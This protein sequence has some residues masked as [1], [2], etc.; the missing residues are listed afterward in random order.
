MRPITCCLTLSLML[1][2]FDVGSQSVTNPPAAGDDGWSVASLEASG[3]DSLKMQRLKKK[4]DDGGHPN[5]HMLLIEHDGRLVYEQYLAGRDQS[6][7]VDI[8]FREFDAHSLHDLRSVS[9]SITALLL[10]IALGEDFEAS[11]SR[12]VIDYFPEFAERV[13]PGVERIT[14]HRLLTMTNGQQWNEMDVPYSSRRNDEIRLY[15]AADPIEY[16]LLKPLREHHPDGWYYNGGTTMLLAAIVTRISGTNLVPYAQRVLFDPLGIRPGDIEWR[17]LGIW[18]K[19]PRLPSAA[20]G[21][22]MRGRDLAR[23]GSLMLHDGRWSGRQVVPRGWVE[24]SSRRH[25][26]Q[27]YAIWSQGGTYGYGYQWWHGRFATPDGGFTAVTGVG[28][29]GQ[30][31]F[32]VRERRIVVTVMGGNYG[33]GLWHVS[34]DI[35][36]EIIDAA[37]N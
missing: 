23:I 33:T 5:T 30:R 37:P 21:L 12:P 18:H 1:A 17:G 8:G 14:L 35:L 36:R 10:G 31:V 16:V 28:Y 4:L 13:P 24:V 27:S 25:T 2:C 11:L 15:H 32:V 7:G 3:F 6:W 19:R 9:K 20:S 29:G 34:E 26:E 22:R